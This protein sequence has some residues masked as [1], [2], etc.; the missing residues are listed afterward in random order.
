MIKKDL[1]NLLDNII[2]YKKKK[3]HLYI[4]IYIVYNE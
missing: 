3:R 4:L 2:F 1:S